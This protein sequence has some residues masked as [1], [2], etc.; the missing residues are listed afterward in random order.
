MIGDFNSEN[1]LAAVACAHS[2]KIDTDKIEKE[3][4]NVQ[5]SLGEWKSKMA[6]PKVIIDYTFDAYEKVCSIKRIT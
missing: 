5:V 3:L 2:L 1:I 6:K 4:K